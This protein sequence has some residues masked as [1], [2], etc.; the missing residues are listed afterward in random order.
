ME[1][2][3]VGGE[4]RGPEGVGGGAVCKVAKLVFRILNSTFHMPL[5]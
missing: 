2:V 1:R 3:V 5:W 4:A